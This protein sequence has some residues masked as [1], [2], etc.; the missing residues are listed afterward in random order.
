MNNY[1]NTDVLIIGTGPVG[2][3]AVFQ[4]GMMNLTCHSVDAL[5]HVGGQCIAL[6]PEKPIYDIPACPGILASD[7]I[8]N[9]EEQIKPLNPKFHLKQTVTSIEKLDSGSWKVI[10]SKGKTFNAKTILIA[11]GVGAFGPNKPP[12]E[13]IEGY[14]G[15]SVFYYVK[16]R[17][18]F[19][20][21]KIVIAGGGDSAMDWAISLKN[22]AKKVYI[23]HRRDKFRALP[24]SVTALNNAADKN[25][26]EKVI[27]YQLKGI[28]GDGEN[29]ESVTVETLSGEER[30]I[31]AD[32]LLP[33]FGLSTNLGPISEW[34]LGVKKSHIEIDPLTGKTNRDGI[35]AIGDIATYPNKL[36]LI[37]TGFSESAQATHSIR[38]YIHPNEV[39]HFEHS[40]TMGIPKANNNVKV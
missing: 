27:P 30:N 40:T 32:F 21:K 23:V 12:L 26:I 11:A 15:K 3:F 24:M 25:E 10:T 20:G 22:I 6:Y 35:Y 14:E 9:L 37:M 1:I 16:D 5:D 2:L 7:L 39:F 13:G 18:K 4:C 33:F 29:L 19:R 17:E 31:E 8:K 28:N 36:K 38:S 34:E